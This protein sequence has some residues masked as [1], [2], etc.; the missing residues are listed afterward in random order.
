MNRLGGDGA[1]AVP[2]RISSGSA[3]I[4]R[5]TRRDRFDSPLAM[6]LDVARIKGALIGS[7]LGDTI[8]LYTGTGF[9]PV[10]IGHLR[11]HPHQSSSPLNT[12]RLHTV[13]LRPSPSLIQSPSRIKTL[14][15]V[16]F[17]P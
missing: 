9:M 12:P 14:T 8:G 10:A 5:V 7:A 3:S 4:N 11:S 2:S 13:A 16:R 6:G 17:Y 1:V 15:A